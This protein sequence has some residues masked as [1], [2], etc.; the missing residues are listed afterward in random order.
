S[1]YKSANNNLT[2]TGLQTDKA[3]L[4][5]F[6]ILGKKIISIQFK[7]TGVHVIQLPKTSVGIY[8][9]E[10]TSSLGKIN[11]KIIIE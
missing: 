7:S 11:K 4:N 5:M 9:I 3:S 2:I 1:I 8:I 10:L 6:S